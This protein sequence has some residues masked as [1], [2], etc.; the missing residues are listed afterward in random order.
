MPRVSVII[1]NW[2]GARWLER[3]LRALRTQRFQDF[4]LIL[5]DNGSTDDSQGL[6]RRD[7]PEVRWVGLPHNM[8]FAAAVNRGI[9]AARGELIALL[10]NDTEVDPGWLEALVDAMD[11]HS[12]VAMLASRMRKDAE[13]D[14]IDS[15]GCRLNWDGF[16]MSLGDGELDDGRFDQE[17]EVF[18]P[19]GGAALYRRALFDAIGLFEESFFAYCEDVDLGFRAQLA[20]HRCLYVPDAVV[21]HIG[22]ATTGTA[23]DFAIRL[24]T[25]NR[26]LMV[27]RCY[28]WPQVL[29]QI[30]KI[31]RA[32][33]W[34]AQPLWNQSRFDVALSAYRSFLRHLPRALVA[35]CRIQA[36]RRVTVDRLNEVIDPYVPRPMAG[37]WRPWRE[38]WVRHG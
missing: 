18:C 19:C 7:Y 17:R 27:I 31:L 36:R 10:N 9:R 4:E 14:R 38:R 11:R 16:A 32:E 28:P 23:S 24:T 12:D 15:V 29:T 20:G 33:C 35:R 3:C 37:S 34:A 25:R 30:P 5:V 8:G 1:P 22:S 26:L 21:Y 6:A 2:N 13:R